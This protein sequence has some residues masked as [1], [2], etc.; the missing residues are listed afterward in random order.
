HF[1]G[2]GTERLEET[3]KSFLPG[4]RVQRLDRDTAR[5]RGAVEEI[6]TRVERGEVDILLGTQMIAKG[7][8]FPNVTLVGVLAADALLALPDFRAGER[9]YQLLAQVAG[10]SG[11][12]DRSEERR[13]GKEGGG[14]ETAD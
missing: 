11:R 5:G 1:G 10:R 9:A 4:A 3:L 12:G 13:V 6:L 2:T 14:R 7:H 8:D